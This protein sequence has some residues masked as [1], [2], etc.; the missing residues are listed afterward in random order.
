M[1]GIKVHAD[2]ATVNL[3][4]WVTP[5]QANLDPESGGLVVYPKVPPNRGIGQ[6]QPEGNVRY[7]RLAENTLRCHVGLFLTLLACDKTG[8]G[9]A[10]R[11]STIEA[12]GGCRN[13]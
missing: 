9:K 1:D 6:D 13:R 8:T 7:R 3:N 4:F 2:S 5:D 10:R 12:Y 11:C